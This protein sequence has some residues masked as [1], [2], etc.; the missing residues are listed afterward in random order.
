M[1][2]LEAVYELRDYVDVFIGSEEGS[3][4]G[5]WRESIG[6]ICDVLVDDSNF[7]NIE[8]GRQ[9]IQLIKNNTPYKE[10]HTMSAIRTDKITDLIYAVDNLSTILISHFESN[11]DDIK[12]AYQKTLLLGRLNPNYGNGN[13][14]DIYDFANNY[15]KTDNENETVNAA[16]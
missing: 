16:L 13:L 7:S 2:S 9:I 6:E 14:V 10:Y 1:G 12:S 3:G 4:Y 15:Y 11:I 5:H 8:I